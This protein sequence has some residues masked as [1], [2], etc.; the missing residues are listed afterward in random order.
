ML[1]DQFD[2]S[3]VNLIP[4]NRRQIELIA[5][6][7]L[8]ESTSA[9]SCSEYN[10]TSGGGCMITVP[11]A[12]FV[13]G[14]SRAATVRLQAVWQGS[15]LA[16]GTAELVLTGASSQLEV[17]ARTALAAGPNRFLYPDETVT[18]PVFANTNG[19]DADEFLL[20]VNFD[21]TVFAAVEEFEVAPG[22]KVSVFPM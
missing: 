5:Q 8:P 4:D 1:Y 2:N 18:V 3:N 22:W 10:A 7:L 16:T 12:L 9:F 20:H 14:E 19:E 15:V 6:I 21:N 13:S 11:S 17:P